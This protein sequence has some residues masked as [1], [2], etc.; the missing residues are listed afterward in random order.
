MPSSSDLLKLLP[1]AIKLTRAI[2]LQEHQLMCQHEY[3]GKIIYFI[4]LARKCKLNFF[5]KSW[6]LH[7]LSFSTVFKKKFPSQE[8]VRKDTEVNPSLHMQTGISWKNKNHVVIFLK[9][10]F[11]CRMESYSKRKKNHHYYKIV[12]SP[13]VS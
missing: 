5:W 6:T 11:S 7:S 13:H 2:L 1:K 3:V 4:K 10:S 8:T 9:I 12:V